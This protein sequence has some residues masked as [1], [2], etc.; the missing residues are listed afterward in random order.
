MTSPILIIGATLSLPSPAGGRGWRAAPGE[1][2][3]LPT[4]IVAPY[5]R[6]AP[7]PLTPLPQA[8]E[9]NRSFI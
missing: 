9:G 6:R 5:R 2:N 7:S 4:K 1:G 8:G 3:L